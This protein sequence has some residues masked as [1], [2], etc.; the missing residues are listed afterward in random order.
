MLKPFTLSLSLVIALG[1]CSVSMAGL[2]DKCHASPQCPAPSAQSAAPSGQC[3]APCAPAKKCCLFDGLKGLCQK[4]PKCYQYEWVLK[5]KRVWNCGGGGCETCGPTASG[6]C[7]S[8]QGG[9]SGQYGGGMYGSG[10]AY[11]APQSAMAAPGELT[12]APATP[13]A[14]DEAPPAPEVA[15]AAPAPAPPAAPAANAP[16]SSLLFT[17]PS[18]N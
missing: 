6:Q 4:K 10:Q 12:P 8:G 15:P 11:T 16:Q 1:A 14:G 13:V 5:K 3:E 7:P 9:P 2:F 18:A 17:T